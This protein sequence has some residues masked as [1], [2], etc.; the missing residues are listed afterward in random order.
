M[1]TI[2]IDYVGCNVHETDRFNI[3]YKMTKGEQIYALFCT[4]VLT[5]GGLFGLIRWMLEVATN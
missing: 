5:L 2:P 3:N 4:Y 1:N